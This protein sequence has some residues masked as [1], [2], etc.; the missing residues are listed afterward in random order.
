MLRIDLDTQPPW[1][2]T[3]RPLAQIKALY[4]L[5]GQKQLGAHDGGCGVWR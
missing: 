4:V 2:P 1:A 3:V 5:D